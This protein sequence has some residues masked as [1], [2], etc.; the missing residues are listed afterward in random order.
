[1][2]LMYN[3]PREGQKS[4]IDGASSDQENTNYWIRKALIENKKHQFFTPLGSSRNIPKYMGKA[5][6]EYVYI[7]LIDDRNI[8]DQGIDANGVASVNGNLYGSSKDIGY[9]LDKLPTLSEEGGM[10]NRVGFTR[11]MIESKISRFGF[12]YDFTNE[13]L[14]HDSDSELKSH[15]ARENIRGANE[16]YE[17]MLQIDLLNAANTVVYAGGATSNGEMSAEETTLGNSAVLPPAIVSYENFARLD[18][19]LIDAEAER[20]TTI[21]T[22]SIKIDTRTIPACRIAY[23]GAELKPL[24]RSL[25]D[26]FGNPAFIQPHQ[27]GDASKLLYNEIGQLDGFRFVEVPKMTNWSGEG[28]EVGVNPGFRT[29][30]GKDKKER[31]NVYPIL[32]VTSESFATLSFNSATG[33][34]K[35]DIITKMPGAQTA[36]GYNDPYGEKG[37]SS[38]KFYYGT[39]ILHPNRIGLI[40]T[41]APL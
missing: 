12:F 8:N 17:M 6:T 35:F 30:Q 39:L 11:E 28:A 21:V 22:G 9:I 7:P 27:Y 5:V 32:V 37:F 34:A 2:A 10:V 29:A 40:K 24:L 15:L 13:S 1:M 18:Q 4:S 23:V 38:L 33:A 16:L 20:S 14:V 3:G 26:T 19:K 25:K 31:Y 36:D 41:V